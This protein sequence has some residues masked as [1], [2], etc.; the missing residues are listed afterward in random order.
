MFTTTVKHQLLVRRPATATWPQ[1][2]GS[3]L[4]Q[5]YI[6]ALAKEHIKTP[7]SISITQ[8]PATSQQH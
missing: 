8:K 1:F 3:K 4:A 5:G 2:T 7:Y 6:K